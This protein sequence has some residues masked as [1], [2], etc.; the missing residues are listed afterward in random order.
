MVH[1]YVVS[2]HLAVAD[3]VAELIVFAVEG[4]CQEAQ[5]LQETKTGS[6]VRAQK[7]NSGGLWWSGSS[8]HLSGQLLL[9]VHQAL[10]VSRVIAAALAGRDGA[11]E[12]GA[13]DLRGDGRGG[14]QGA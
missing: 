14:G 3:A 6:V 12:R 7:E 10:D 13:G 5:A 9:P 4:V 11:F 2:S 1:L 8:S